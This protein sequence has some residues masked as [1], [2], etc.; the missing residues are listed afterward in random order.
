MFTFLL[1]F[2]THLPLRNNNI[3]V[4]DYAYTMYVSRAGEEEKEE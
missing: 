3:G 2:L 1:I 4:S